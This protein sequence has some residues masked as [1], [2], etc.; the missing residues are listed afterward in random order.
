MRG[1]LQS[2]ADRAAQQARGSLGSLSAQKMEQVK[3]FD[4]HST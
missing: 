2:S 4:S 1:K 3:L